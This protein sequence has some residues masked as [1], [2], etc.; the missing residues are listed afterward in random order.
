M[1]SAFFSL[2][3]CPFFWLGG[4]GGGGEGVYQLLVGWGGGCLSTFG[5]VGEGVFDLLLRLGINQASACSFG[6]AEFYINYPGWILENLPLLKACA[7]HVSP[8][9]AT[10]GQEFRED[11]Q[12]ERGHRTAQREGRNGCKESSNKTHRNKSWLG[13]PVPP[14]AFWPTLA[15]ASCNSRPSEIN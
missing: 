10:C 11:G 4:G 7:W 15:D 13:I 5:W 1:L 6:L 14:A 9:C 12:P 2:P 3:F 8:M